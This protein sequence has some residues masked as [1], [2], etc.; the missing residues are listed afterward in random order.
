MQTS[1]QALRAL[2]EE[3]KD[4]LL[5]G[6]YDK[7]EAFAE[8]KQQVVQSLDGHDLPQATLEVLRRSLA[9]NAALLGSAAQ[10]IQDA[11]HLLV[12]LRGGQATQ[13]YDRHGT[14]KTMRTVENKL[15]RKA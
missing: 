10:G 14:S 2:L 13:M 15:E 9:Q 4:A 6:K 5:R 3:E 7:L 11:R 12:R 1:L 8:A